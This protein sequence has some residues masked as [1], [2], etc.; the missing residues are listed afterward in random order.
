MESQLAKYLVL[1]MAAKLELL[2]VQMLDYYLGMKMALHLG[3]HYELVLVR[4]KGVHLEF[5]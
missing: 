2:M 3:L 5:L 1:R 4:L